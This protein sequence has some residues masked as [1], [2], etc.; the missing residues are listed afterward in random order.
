MTPEEL[1]DD[2]ARPKAPPVPGLTPLQEI[3]GKRLSMIHR[4]Y[5]QELSAVARLMGDIR[6]GI[7]TPDKLPSAIAG[8]SL[9]ENLSLFGTVCGRECALLQNHHDIEE[10][11]MFPSLAEGA[12]AGLRAVIDRL[13]AEH[14]VIHALIGDLRLAADRLAED[15][16]PEAFADCS[17]VFN[18][19]DRA[20]RSHFGYEEVELAPALGASGMAI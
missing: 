3:E 19:L 14:K 11:W 17:T 2:A 16:A 9:T 18:R 10:Q 6:A 20:I 4:M 1:E 8:L 7:A 15:G 5:R 13:I 12:N